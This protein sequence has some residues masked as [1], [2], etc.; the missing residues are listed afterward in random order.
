MT[1]VSDHS[2][3]LY[4]LTE[5]VVNTSPEFLAGFNGLWEESVDLVTEGVT[6]ELRSAYDQ[7]LATT[8]VLLDVPINHL[9]MM[10]GLTDETVTG[11]VTR[12]LLTS[13]LVFRPMIASIERTVESP[14]LLFD[15]LLV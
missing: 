14:R 3:N 6:D 10:I 1:T 15:S 4:T 8:Q 11:K 13:V 12:A 9:Q 2:S 7:T 5:Q